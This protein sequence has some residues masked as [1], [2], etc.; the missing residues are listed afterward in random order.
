M[1]IETL[2]SLTMWI[3]FCYGLTLFFVLELP[4]L[5]RVESR[6]PELFLILRQHQP[7]AMLCLWVGGL[8]ILQEMWIK[9]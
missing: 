3:A 8:W 7:I 9:V 2:D 1:T 6:A 5:K 4:V